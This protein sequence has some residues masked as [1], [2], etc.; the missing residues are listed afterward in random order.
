[1]GVIC[2]IISNQ[3]EKIYKEKEKLLLDPMIIKLW[4]EIKK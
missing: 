4:K 2:K 3:K 1:M